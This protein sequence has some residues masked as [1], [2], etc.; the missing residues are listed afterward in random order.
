MVLLDS[1][2]INNVDINIDLLLHGHM[3]FS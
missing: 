2:H 1:I 3:S